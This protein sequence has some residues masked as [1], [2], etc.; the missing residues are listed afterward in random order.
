LALA[1][2]RGLRHSAPGD[3]YWFLVLLVPAAYTLSYFL[4]SVA[5]YYRYLYPST[6]LVQV[7][8][9]GCMSAPLSRNTSAYR[10]GFGAP[11]PAQG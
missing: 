6:L 7:L 9:A 11:R 3:L 2:R 1:A 5:L 8:A 10:D 4:A